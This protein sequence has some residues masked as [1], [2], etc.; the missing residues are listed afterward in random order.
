MDKSKLAELKQIKLNTSARATQNEIVEALRLQYDTLIADGFTAQEAV[1]ELRA[2]AH[3]VDKTIKLTAAMFGE[4]S[5]NKAGF[6]VQQ[7]PLRVIVFGWQQEL[8]AMIK[9]GWTETGLIEPIKERIKRERPDLIE[10]AKTAVTEELVHEIV[11][12]KRT[13][14][15]TDFLAAS[16]H[17]PLEAVLKSWR[18]KIRPYLKKGWTVENLVPLVRDKV[19]AERPDL[20]TNKITVEMLSAALEKSSKKDTDNKQPPQNNNTPAEPSVESTNEPAP[21]PEPR[22]LNA[23]II[24]EWTK[25]HVD[26][27]GR[28]HGLQVGDLIANVAGVTA[29][30][31]KIEDV[32][33]GKWD[34]E[35]GLRVW[36]VA[37]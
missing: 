13:R 35:D 7:T 37:I 20:D 28:D 15:K 24:K 26:L 34:K 5:T 32:Q 23:E 6:K 22:I 9:R 12:R 17:Q 25:D 8:R 33:F 10:E 27:F 31:G 11:A 1:K 21:E 36:F 2:A 18:G 14:S 16:E 19:R 29:R 3:K 30:I 4:N